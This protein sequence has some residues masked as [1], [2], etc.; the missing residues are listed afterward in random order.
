MDCRHNCAARHDGNCSRYNVL[1]R[2]VYRLAERCEQ[3]GKTVASRSRGDVTEWHLR[4]E[5][6][7]C[8]SRSLPEHRRVA[9]PT[10]D[11]AE[12]EIDL[13]N[14]LFPKDRYKPLAELGQGAAGNVYLCRDRVLGKKVAVKTLRRSTPDQLIGFHQEARAT[15]ALRHPNI[16]NILDFG[17]TAEGAPYMVLDFVPGQSLESYIR[18]GPL[19]VDT[20]LSIVSQLAEALGYAHGNG[21]FHRDLKPSNVLIIENEETLSVRLIDFGVAKLS[22]AQEPTIV[23]GITVVGT[24]AYMS[25]DQVNGFQYDARSEI[26]S[27]GCIL[28]ECLTGRPPFCGENAMEMISRHSIDKPPKMADL[29][30]KEIPKEVQQVVDRCL[31]KAPRDRYASMI[32]LQEELELIRTN[33]SQSPSKTASSEPARPGKQILWG[34]ILG[35]SVIGIIVAFTMISFSLMSDMQKLETAN[36]TKL[37]EAPPTSRF[38]FHSRSVQPAL[39]VTDQDLKELSNKIVSRLYLCDTPVRGTGLKYLTE[40]EVKMLNLD[41]SALED[42]YFKYINQLPNLRALSVSETNTSIEGL[43]QLTNVDLRALNV[44]GCRKFDDSC[45]DFVINRWPAIQTLSV[46]LTGI[47]N[48]ALPKIARLPNLTYLGITGMKSSGQQF[49]ALADSNI[50]ELYC[51]ESSIDASGLKAIARMKALKIV[52]VRDC[53][54]LADR[55]IENFRKSRPDVDCHV[56]GGQ[57]R[58]NRV[59]ELNSLLIN[60]EETL[61]EQFQKST[62]KNH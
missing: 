13:D 17:T 21:I 22:F 15:S 57:L 48:D 2:K 7:S 54:A 51:A 52:S 35:L 50:K 8:Q 40:C 14:N 42:R 19:P 31:M 45:I 29:V 53:H 16:V 56:I 39:S 61:E 43:K 36:K 23:Q 62:A 12:V 41:R 32:E 58:K 26:Y 20:T 46:G 60:S 59:D 37:P 24:P 28:F 34:A 47:T 25:P 33:I 9:R 30:R 11:Q 4:Q 3:C 6:C 1:I 5:L 10:S 27:L 38:V 55:S 18:N 44:T 49:S